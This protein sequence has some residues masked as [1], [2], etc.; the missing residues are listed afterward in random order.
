L[1]HDGSVAEPGFKNAAG[2]WDITPHRARIQRNRREQLE[3]WHALMESGDPEVAVESSRMISSVNHAA[4]VALEVLSKTTKV[5]A[6]APHFSSGWHESGDRAKGRFESHWGAPES[7]EG[8]ILQGPN[9]HVGNPF[10]GERNPGMGSPH[11]Y[12]ALDLETLIE[13]AIPATEYKPLYGEKKNGDGEVVDDT[14]VYD[15][16]YG[17]WRYQVDRDGKTITEE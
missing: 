12:S 2:N 17:T 13:S 4:A 15:A 14:S 1:R 9:L 7:W 10:F 6:L 16:A 11:D 8:V 3:L 5:S